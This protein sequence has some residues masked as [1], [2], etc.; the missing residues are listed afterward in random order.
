[1][2]TFSQNVV[3]LPSQLSG[4]SPTAFF[5]NNM[6]WQQANLKKDPLLVKESASSSGPSASM[7][8]PTYQTTV[9]MPTRTEPRYSALHFSPFEEEKVSLQTVSMVENSSSDKL[10]EP[11]HNGN[12]PLMWAVEQGREDL[13]QLFVDQGAFVNMQNF[14]GETALYLA[15]SRG[16]TRICSFLLENGADVSI[17]TLEG[18][19]A[20][21]TAAANGHVEVLRSLAR[22]GAFMNSQ[23]EEGDTPLHYAVREGQEM[24][25]EFL[26]KECKV[27][28]DLRNEDLESPVELAS[29]L[30]ES[31]MVQFLSAFSKE[32]KERQHGGNFWHFQ[33]QSFFGTQHC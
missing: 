15:A 9:V 5:V 12:T 31:R 18:C 16:F 32:N 28:I 21:H 33:G 13:I 25:V 26:V 27:D 4:G 23:D 24:A 14:A 19:S 11:D 8:Q 10:N 17:S 20:V 22:N 3:P 29:C 7:L 30:D 2:N 1:M 6:I